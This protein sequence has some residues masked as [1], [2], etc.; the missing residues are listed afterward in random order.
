MALAMSSDAVA[1]RYDLGANW[2]LETP[3]DV[4]TLDWLV[5][6]HALTFVES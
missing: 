4:G 2:A 1:Q 6:L 3:D 5:L